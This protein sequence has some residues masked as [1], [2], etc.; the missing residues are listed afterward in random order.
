M[1][2]ELSPELSSSRA[3]LKEKSK[4]TVIPTLMSHPSVALSVPVLLSLSH[5]KNSTQVW[6]SPASKLIYE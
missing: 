3:A 4:V 1:A 5:H 2:E 6:E